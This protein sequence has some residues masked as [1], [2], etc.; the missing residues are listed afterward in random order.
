[1]RATRLSALIVLVA[2]AGGCTELRPGL[3]ADA[4]AGRDGGVDADVDVD[5]GSTGCAIGF[6]DLDGRSDNGCECEIEAELCNSADDDCDGATDE[7]SVPCGIVG[8]CSQGSQA[9]V[10]GALQACVPDLA[11]RTE[12]CDGRD[13]E[14]CDGAVDEDCPCSPEL[15]TREC[16]D[17]TGRCT[18]GTQT[19]QSGGWGTCVGGMGPIAETCDNVDEDCD[20]TIDGMIRACGTSVGACTLGNETCTAGVFSG[21]TG[22]G[23]GTEVC[24]A[25][26]LDENCDATENEGCICDDGQTRPCSCAGTETCDISGRWGTC[27]GSPTVET[28][29]GLDDDCNGTTDEGTTCG[30]CTQVNNGSRSYLICGDNLERRTWSQARTYCMMFGYDLATV[31]TAAEN[32]FLNAQERALF[33]NSVLWWYG[34][35]DRAIEGTWV[36]DPTGSAVVYTDWASGGEPNNGTSENCMANENRSS[37]QWSSDDCNAQYRFVCEAQSS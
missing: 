4:E 21:C 15:S 1:M 16:G 13:D 18:F 27:V 33:S 36:W 19:C 12:E 2:L 24:D 23:P 26:R 11:P 20:G 22:I 35:S 14:D 10:A 9:C 28:C 6:V 25:A 8:T 32:D 5:A 30:V 34:G 17:D 7:E 29:N 3:A 37:P 31:E